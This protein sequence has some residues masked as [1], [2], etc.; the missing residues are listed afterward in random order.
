MYLPTQKSAIEDAFL[1]K[2]TS[3]C[4]CSFDHNDLRNS[5]VDCKGSELVYTATMEY[6]SED[7]TET[8]SFIALR[9]VTQAPFAMAIGGMPLTVTSACSNCQTSTSNAVTFS[10]VAGGGLFAGGFVTATVVII[11]IVIVIV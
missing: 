9:I 3:D 1:S 8:A 2:I 10:P 5:S 6:S 11:I 7:G 4:Q